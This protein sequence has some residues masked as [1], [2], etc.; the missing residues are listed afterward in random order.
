MREEGRRVLLSCEVLLIPNPPFS[1]LP[2][3]IHREGEGGETA[4]S[5]VGLFMGS[6]S[7][8]MVFI[9]C[10][11]HRAKHRRW[12]DEYGLFCSQE[13]SVSG[14]MEVC[15][16]VIFSFLKLQPQ[17]KEGMDPDGLLCM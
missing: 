14:E 12:K 16:E 3:S 5:F 11:R 9:L 2:A 10:G 15:E 8:H 13:G 1:H 7:K 17:L 6:C 4:G